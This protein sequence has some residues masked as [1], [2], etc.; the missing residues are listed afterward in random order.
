MFQEKLL[1]WSDNDKISGSKFGLYFDR[2]YINYFKRIQYVFIS[3]R[4]NYVIQLVSKQPIKKQIRIVFQIA[5]AKRNE[6]CRN[7][8]KNACRSRNYRCKSNFN[9]RTIDRSL[10][11]NGQNGQ[12]KRSRL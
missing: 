7:R 1:I 8:R 11:S 3:S 4:I 2:V 9:T 10:Q 6:R 5:I 12:F